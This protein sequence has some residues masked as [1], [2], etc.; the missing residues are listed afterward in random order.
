M[1]SNRVRFKDQGEDHMATF[2]GTDADEESNR[3][4]SRAQ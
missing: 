4:L 1:L 3:D 2:T